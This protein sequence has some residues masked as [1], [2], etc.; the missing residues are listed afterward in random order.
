M[1]YSCC[2]IGF[3]E[4]P[5]LA[6]EAFFFLDGSVKVNHGTLIVALD[7]GNW[8]NFSRFHSLI[9][10]GRTHPVAAILAQEIWYQK[11]HQLELMRHNEQQRNAEMK[12]MIS[13]SQIQLFLDR[14][15][16][17]EREH[18]LTAFASFANQSENSREVAKVNKECVKTD[19]M[20][21]SRAP[22]IEREEKPDRV[23][24]GLT[25]SRESSKLTKNQK[26]SR[27][28]AKKELERKKKVLLIEQ[29]FS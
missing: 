13:G 22:S 5:K 10:V 7:W 19:P 27:A 15:G 28:K 16:E 1:C 3:I 20:S 2:K 11:L 6:L 9:M 21:L 24:Y 12:G 25:L 23:I 14:L 26:K 8:H 17:E 4:F 29:A 18:L